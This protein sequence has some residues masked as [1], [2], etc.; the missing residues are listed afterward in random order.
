MAIIKRSVLLFLQ[1][2]YLVVLIC[3]FCIWV[4]YN[5]CS[6]SASFAYSA[7]YHKQF[8]KVLRE[9]T[10]QKERN[11]TEQIQSRVSSQEENGETKHIIFLRLSTNVSSP[12]INQQSLEEAFQIV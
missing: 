9:E 2:Y 10:D 11:N 7:F 6:C 3:I 8:L 1:H 12:Q 4:I 5:S